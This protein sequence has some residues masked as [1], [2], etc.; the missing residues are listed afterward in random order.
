MFQEHKFVCCQLFLITIYFSIYVSI[1]IDVV[2]LRDDQYSYHHAKLFG[3]QNH[4]ISDP[5]SP[6]CVYFVDTEWDVRKVQLSAVCTR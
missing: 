5:W 1:G 6:D 3:I 4:L 2:K